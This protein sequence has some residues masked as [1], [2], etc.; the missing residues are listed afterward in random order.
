M[1]FEGLEA[2]YIAGT[3][4][5]G[6]NVRMYAGPGGN[7]GE[8]LAWDPV[9]NEKVWAVNENFPVWSGA[10]VT[11][12]DV[13]FYGTMDGW[14]KALD[15]RS[16]ALLWQFKCGS[17]IIGQ[18]IS[19]RGPDGKRSLELA[20]EV[21][22][23]TLAAGHVVTQRTR[24]NSIGLVLVDSLTMNA[25]SAI[26]S[27]SSDDCEEAQRERPIENDDSS[28]FP[29]RSSVI[30]VTVKRGI[31]GR[32][33]VSVASD[34]SPRSTIPPLS[35]V[36]S[37]TSSSLRYSLAAASLPKPSVTCSSIS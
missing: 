21:P 31:H 10:L 26:Q 24:V 16:G 27:A 36:A 30:S 35:N 19:Y 14:F 3:P 13:V 20:A 4:Y 17:G 28:I 33:K 9:K 2:N 34:A 1:D 8:F 15:A 18:P 11:A 7:R 22:R 25:W 32:K 6:A 37:P 23:V 29:S 12:G 5:V